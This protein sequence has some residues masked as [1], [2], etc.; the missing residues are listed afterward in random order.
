ML[1]P[2]SRLSTNLILATVPRSWSSTADFLLTAII[3][4]FSVLKAYFLFGST[5]IF[6]QTFSMMKL[7]KSKTVSMLSNDNLQTS[8]GLVT[9]VLHSNLHQLVDKKKEPKISLIF[10]LPNHYQCKYIQIGW[11][12][13]KLNTK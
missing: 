1:F 11:Y 8:L 4:C 3:I 12:T 2:F 6:E 10:F 9:N 7:T 5:Y 13:L